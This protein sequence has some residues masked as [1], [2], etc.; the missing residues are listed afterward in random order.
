MPIAQEQQ[1]PTIPPAIP[2]RPLPRASNVPTVDFVAD[3][4][5]AAQQTITTAAMTTGFAY[6]RNLP[7]HIDFLGVRRLF[8]Q[9]YA[10]PEFASRFKMPGK[11]RPSAFN[12]QGKWVGDEGVDDKASLDLPAR[13]FRGPF[14]EILKHAYGDDFQNIIAFFQAV[15][16]Q[17]VPLVV[18]ATSDAIS[19]RT[20]ADVDVWSIR[21]DGNLHFRLIDYHRSTPQPRQACRAHRDGS[22]ATIIFQDGTG[23]LEIQDN[24]TG[25]WVGI[26]GNEVVLMWGRS[27][28]VF[29]GGEVKAV[30]H[31]VNTIATERRTPAIVF[32]GADHSTELKPLAATHRVGGAVGANGSGVTVGMMHQIMKQHRQRREAFQRR[33]AP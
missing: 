25:Q 13:V 23:G 30:N 9:C 31:R 29:S 7:I 17:L 19:N 21:R 27:G 28:E 2:P 3:S 6:L 16:E 12:R 15:E 26:P 24:R 20:G 5:L 22:I 11:D 33:F 18:Q 10:S 32:I 1:R 8:D 14:A 4:Q